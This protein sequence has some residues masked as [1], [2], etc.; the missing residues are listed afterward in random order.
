MCANTTGSVL[1]IEVNGDWMQYY[2]RTTVSASESVSLYLN[3][4][5]T[6][7]E[8][9]IEK[10]INLHESTNLLHTHMHTGRNKKLNSMFGA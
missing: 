7:L 5:E 6:V 4:F 10:H 3:C 8:K 9:K 1:V 2:L